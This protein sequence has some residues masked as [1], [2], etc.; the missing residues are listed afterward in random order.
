MGANGQSRVHP[1]LLAADAL[2]SLMIWSAVLHTCISFGQ[3]RRTD[4]CI[5]GGDDPARIGR[6]IVG[7]KVGERGATSEV[8][9]LSFFVPVM[10]PWPDPFRLRLTVGAVSIWPKRG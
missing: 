4:H 8:S 6:K 5:S 1:L 9:T 2:L 3:A 7:P 10:T